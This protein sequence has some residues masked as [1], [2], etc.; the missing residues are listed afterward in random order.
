[1]HLLQLSCV[2]T[3]AF[4]RSLPRKASLAPSLRLR[5]SIGLQR[6]LWRAP[7]RPLGARPLGRRGATLAK[8]RGGYALAP[9]VNGYRAAL[10][11][12]PLATNCATAACLSMT[13]D[14]VAQRLCAS[15][16]CA[17]W[18]RPRTLWIA[19]WGAVISGWMLQYWFIFLR[20]LFPLYKTSNLQLA[21][22][23]FVNQL[24]MSPLLNLGF[25]SFVILT[26]DAPVLRM[27]KHK[28]VALRA[29]IRA[30]LP[31]TIRRSCLFWAVIQTLNFR[32]LSP[33]WVVINT[34]LAYLLW[35]TYLS[36]VAHVARK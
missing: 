4:A 24:V 1:M 11:A 6:A 25:F 13:S 15:D 16:E 20:F 21:G 18:D 12:A 30:D 5:D 3:A 35:N 33:R 17:P 19:V 31:R 8:L 22:K 9:L 34:N 26:R 32:Y 14:A 27:P 10:A 23:V 28:R 29:K 36:I 7:T 2:V